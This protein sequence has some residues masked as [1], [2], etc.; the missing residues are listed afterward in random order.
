MG[1]TVLKFKPKGGDMVLGDVP[2]AENEA[3]YRRRKAGLKTLLDNLNREWK[4]I[5]ERHRGKVEELG[6]ELDVYLMGLA[7][8]TKK[9]YTGELK[10]ADAYF[11]KEGKEI[12]DDTLPEYL[13]FRFQ[14][15]KHAPASILLGVRA[16]KWRADK[17][18][19][20]DPF[21]NKSK[22]VMF[23]IKSQGKGRGRGK[24]A[25]ILKEHLERIEECCEAER[26]LLGLRD[27]CLIC[28]GFD[29]ALRVSEISAVRVEHVATGRDGKVRLFIPSSKTD[30]GGQG[31]HVRISEGTGEVIKEW[32][33]Q[34]GISSG[35]LFRPLRADRI[36][37]TALTP[38]AVRNVI[39]KRAKQAGVEGRIS[40]HSLRRG[41]SQSLSL[42][43]ISIQQV[44]VHCRWKSPAM[45]IAYSEGA[46][47]A[48][49]AIGKL[50]E[51]D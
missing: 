26:T 39:R 23:H 7:P 20:P 37:E 43:G 29:A 46:E 40:G 25:P 5:Q 17:L 44:A 15:L 13:L 22:A 45:V 33:R 3:Y 6:S 48:D 35:P 34:S 31:V 4:M 12:S 32:R 19:D 27:Y 49:S 42:K 41:C 9:A 47:V 50:Y 16:L 10:R 38:H 28:L 21:G 8:G 2:L 1:A 24:V 36:G 14:E 51:E 11:E 30:Q 18:D